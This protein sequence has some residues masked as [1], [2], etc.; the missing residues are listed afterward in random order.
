MPKSGNPA[1]PL[2]KPRGP[3]QTA[4]A[5][6]RS[7]ARNVCKHN[8]YL[9]GESWMEEEDKMHFKMK[10]R[11]EKRIRCNRILPCSGKVFRLSW[12]CNRLFKK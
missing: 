5:I 9:G 11:E 6:I 7:G 3:A 4:H 2:P 8:L 1:P 12:S 10:K